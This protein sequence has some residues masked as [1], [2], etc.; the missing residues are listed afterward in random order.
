MTS[1]TVSKGS[2]C[3][4]DVTHSWVGK[5]PFLPTPTAAMR[6]PLIVS[7]DNDR[8][9]FILPLAFSDAAV[10][11][12]VLVVGLF[13]EGGDVSGRV[14]VCSCPPRPASRSSPENE[15]DSISKAMVKAGSL[16]FLRRRNFSWCALSTDSRSCCGPSFRSHSA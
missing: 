4:Q 2:P 9:A 15:V 11:V 6:S 12:L 8:R 7:D 3:C 5:N 10:V 14:S 16:S 1:I 13:S